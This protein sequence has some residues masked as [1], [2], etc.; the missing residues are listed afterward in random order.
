M[1]SQ[2]QIALTQTYRFRKHNF[3]GALMFE[4]SILMDPGFMRKGI[5]ADNGLIGWYKNAGIGTHHS[6]YPSQL[7]RI[8]PSIKVQQRPTRAQTHDNFFQGCIA[9]ALTDAVDCHLDLAR[10][11][12]DPCQGVGSS[13]SKVIMA[14]SRDDHIFDPRD[15]F[16]NACDKC[17]EFI[18]GGITHRVRDVER[19]RT[20][21]NGFLEHHV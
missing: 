11:G 7:G 14:V 21:F 17:A 13:Q 4:H 5:R 3:V 10:T 12:L 18:W 2:N 20:R 1:F 16:N 8:D 19:R 15:I 9:G 6:T